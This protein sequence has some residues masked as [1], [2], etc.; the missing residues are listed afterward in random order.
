MPRRT[1]ARCGACFT[2]STLGKLAGREAP[3]ILFS[4][5]SEVP[6][7]ILLADGIR[8]DTLTRAIDSGQA[9]AL[10]RL[11]EEGGMHTLTSCF[12]SVTGPAYTPMLLGRF[13]ALVGLPGVRWYDRSRAV[14]GFPGYARSYMGY[15]WSYLN[16]DLHSD[17]PT[18]F[19]LVPASMSAL[20]MLSRGVQR[21][22]KIGS[23]T[24]RSAIR[25]AL[26][27]F[28]GDVQG[29]LAIDRAAAAEVIR[30][31][32]EDRPEF[33][34]A[35]FTGIDKLSHAHG[36]G[37]P[38]VFEAL[39]IVDETARHLREDAEVGGYWDD[40]Q[41]WIVSDHGH[42][43]VHT[44]D[45]LAGAVTALGHR[46]L[47]HPWIF[48]RSPS[49]AVMVSGNAMA[50]VYVGLEA[51]RRL[52]WTH[53]SGEWSG[54]L[55]ALLARESV[56]LAA[57]VDEEGV[58]VMGRGRGQARITMHE[59]HYGYRRQTGDPLEIG[60]DVADLDDVEALNAT[61]HTSYPDSIV[62]L[63]HLA[64]CPRAGDIVLSATPGWDFR[65]RYEPIPHVS[66]HGGLHR[67]HMLVPLIVNRPIAGTP[68]RTVD[69]MPSALAA[70]G[71][72]APEELDGRSFIE[73][74]VTV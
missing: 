15:E 48:T 61:I 39:S 18:I 42:G 70:L 63:W 11:R 72:G 71:L 68:R 6:V 3:V 51:R 58:L 36:Q 66:A 53:L 16:R 2:R 74:L 19:E 4:R 40:F 67:D 59:G 1:L 69:V 50:H 64:N 28:R 29:W 44:H 24:L 13:P 52:P 22:N 37:S 21:H 26:T 65:A 17:A 30:R 20:S 56:D 60:A 38:R 57:V 27:H 25:A 34:F 7:V 35:A 73:S 9:P 14:C 31:V 54:L 49:V 45:D 10:A 47:A 46:T 5:R 33:V 32:R 8:P 55:H 43:D 12:P 41:L 23:L 62:Q